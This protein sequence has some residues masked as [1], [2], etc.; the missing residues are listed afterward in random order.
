M[1]AKSYAAN[2]RRLFASALQKE[3]CAALFSQQTTLAPSI[4]RHA[5]AMISTRRSLP[6]QAAEALSLSPQ[7]LPS[8]RLSNQ[9]SGMRPF[10]SSGRTMDALGVRYVVPLHCRRVNVGMAI[11]FLRSM[12]D[13]LQLI[14]H[15]LLRQL[16][17]HHRRQSW[18]FSS[19][20]WT[21]YLIAK[22]VSFDG[23]K[24]QTCLLIVIW[25]VLTVYRSCRHGEKGMCDYCMPLEVCPASACCIV[26]F[27]VI[28][29][30]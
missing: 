12:S 23:Q 29:A 28:A 15:L 17:H 6:C 4:A 27:T 9:A 3:P 25:S 30:V 21:T 8:L 16:L 19:I 1:V 7:Q 14:R 24:T 13:H 22:T 11:C 10:P 18:L 5:P 2:A 26:S 20:L